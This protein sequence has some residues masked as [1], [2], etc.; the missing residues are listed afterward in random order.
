MHTTHVSLHCNPRLGLAPQPS[1]RGLRVVSPLLYQLS[2]LALS[3][4]AADADRATK[5]RYLN[6]IA[7]AA[8]SCWRI[9]ILP[10]FARITVNIKR[11]VSHDII[12]SVRGEPFDIAQE[13]PV[14]P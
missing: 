7:L 6:L 4:L 10:Q 5:G 9:A 11:Y 13:S 2:Y 1:A 14:E 8:S 12:Y 3:G